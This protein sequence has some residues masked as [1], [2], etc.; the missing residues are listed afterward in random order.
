MHINHAH[1]CARNSNCPTAPIVPIKRHRT[2]RPWTCAA[3]MPCCCS[4]DA[5]HGKCN[6]YTK[7]HVSHH[8][9]ISLQKVVPCVKAIRR[10]WCADPTVRTQHCS[11]RRESGIQTPNTN[12]KKIKSSGSNRTASSSAWSLLP[13][14]INKSCQLSKLCKLKTYQVMIESNWISISGFTG[15]ASKQYFLVW[16]I[17]IFRPVNLHWFWVE[18]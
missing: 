3:S 4:T 14:S 13:N 2:Q 1:A 8:A 16:P 10:C 7:I 6:R 18:N 12:Q 5:C 15:L 11:T 17:K 9:R